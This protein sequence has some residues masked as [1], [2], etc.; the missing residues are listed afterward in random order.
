MDK[1]KIRI[2]LLEPM[3]ASVNIV[4]GSHVWVEYPVDAWIDGEIS[5]INGLEIHVHARFLESII[6]QNTK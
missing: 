4:V 3:A 2:S 6:T 1:L 5:R